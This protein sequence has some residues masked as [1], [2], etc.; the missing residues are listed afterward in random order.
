M[1]DPEI[2]YTREHNPECPNFLDKQDNWFKKI[3]GTLDAYFHKLHSDGI[4]RHTRHAD[5]VSSTEENQLWETG[6]LNSN[7]PKGLQNA[8]FYTIGKMFCRR[9]GQEHRALK[10]SQLKCDW[11]KYVCLL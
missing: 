3:Q 2:L 4:G 9:G 8:V 1:W 7:T 6:V 11:D 5:T 10:L